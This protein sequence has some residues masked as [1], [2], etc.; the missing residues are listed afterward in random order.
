MSASPVDAG[1]SLTPATITSA[2]AARE[3]DV[4]AGTRPIRWSERQYDRRL[5]PGPRGRAQMPALGRLLKV[6]GAG[7]A[8][9]ACRMGMLMGR[10]PSMARSTRGDVVPSMARA[11]RRR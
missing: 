9:T 3:I 11:R 2:G 7:C 1:S 4:D 10:P 6:L 8:V 5:V